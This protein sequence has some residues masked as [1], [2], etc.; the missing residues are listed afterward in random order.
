MAR[1]ADPCRDDGATLYRRQFLLTPPAVPISPALQ[2]I[3]ADWPT[4][5]LPSGWCLR[6]HP[7]LSVHVARG[8]VGTAVA[9][10]V[11]L[12]PLDPKADARTVV[13]RIA[14]AVTVDDLLRS[15]WH[16]S[17]RWVLIWDGPSDL[18]V[19]ADPCGLRQV[20]HAASPVG[21]VVGSQPPLLARLLDLGPTG[22]A[23][24][25]RF[26]ASAA[27]LKTEC[28]AVGTATPFKGCRRLPA[29]HWLAPKTGKLTRFFPHG[30]V[31]DLP[32]DEAAELGATLLTGTIEASV[33][34]GPVHQA[35]TAGWDSRLLLA[36]AAAVKDDIGFFV[37]SPGYAEGLHPEV[38]IPRALAARLGLRLNVIDTID[39]P[40]PWFRE[41]LAANTG[42]DRRGRKLR[43][44][45]HHHLAGAAGICI[46][47][48]GGE[49]VRDGLL[50]TR[51]VSIRTPTGFAAALAYG[52]DPYVE[53]VL[54]SWLD[55][56]VSTDTDYDLMDLLY[57]EQRMSTWGALYPTELEV[58]T[59]EISPFN[60]RLYL[61]TLLRIPMQDRA[62]PECRLT[63]RMI[64]ICWPDCLNL[65]INPHKELLRRVPMRW[66]KTGARAL[67]AVAD[68]I[69]RLRRR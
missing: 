54:H 19:V 42:L 17:G 41:R 27:F 58:A 35:L 53:S 15:T 66:R 9:L 8:P 48:N 30:S 59:E 69:R 57:W 11:L 16:L 3:L 28:A 56:I 31:G 12:D 43:H 2:P 23:A 4:H 61:A 10:G 25:T 49:I 63:R 37:F 24:V 39:D 55:G 26:Q 45:W 60:N 6:A 7:D 40:P 67:A 36:A 44:V 14:A 22:D 13:G 65:P 51:G 29:N 32:L 1:I 50:G 33:R 34:R 46:N 62:E 52:G 5:R 47:G 68:R 64:E 38:T 20:H 18:V 21:T